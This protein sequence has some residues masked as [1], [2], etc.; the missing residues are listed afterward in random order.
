VWVCSM[1]HIPSFL[2]HAEEL[3]QKGVE[4][5]VCVSVN[6]VFV[7]DAWGKSLGADGILMV[8]RSALPLQS[9]SQTIHADTCN[10]STRRLRKVGTRSGARTSHRNVTY[11]LQL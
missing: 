11:M 6:D 2:Q 10:P 1:L 7:M 3:K 4:L 9:T 8:V 5:L